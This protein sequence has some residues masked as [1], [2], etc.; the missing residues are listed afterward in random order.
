MNGACAVHTIH[1]LPADLLSLQ[2]SDAR[3][4]LQFTLRWPKPRTCQPGNTANVKRLIWRFVK[5]R[6]NG[7]PSLAEEYSAQIVRVCYHISNNDPKRS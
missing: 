7:S 2:H 1:D 6:E 5:E 4:Q 3:Q